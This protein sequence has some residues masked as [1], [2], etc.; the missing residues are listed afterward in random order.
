MK[1]STIGA[2]LM[3]LGLTNLAAS[4]QAADV[5]LKLISAEWCGPCKT[6]EQELKANGKNAV[7]VQVL[8]HRHE[9]PIVV[10]KTHEGSEAPGRDNRL[11]KL[12][13]CF[14]EVQLLVNWKVVSGECLSDL[15]SI[16]ETAQTYLEKNHVPFD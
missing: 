8:G 11:G 3:L 16:Q 15:K 1:N 13:D 6:L 7:E 14:P 5:T 10:V 4:A 9:I 2:F 12:T